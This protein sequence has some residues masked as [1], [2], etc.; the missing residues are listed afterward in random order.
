MLDDMPPYYRDDP[1]TQAVIVAYANEYDRIEAAVR[2]VQAAGF[3]TQS[4]DVTLV[5]GAATARLLSMWETLLNL[6]V[7]PA[8]VPLADRQAKVVAHI[9]KRKS[10]RGADWAAT[11][12]EALGGSTSWTYTEGPGAYQVT[13]NLPYVAGSYTAGQVQALVSAI[14]PAHLDMI[15]RYGQGFLV[16][17]NFVGIDPL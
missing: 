10:G 13:V 17:I 11:I 16:G 9:R 4:A 8:G 6:P 7:A 15:V 12:T 3:P 2:Q 1:M 14:S 5:V